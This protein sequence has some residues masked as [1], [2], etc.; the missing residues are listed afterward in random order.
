MSIDYSC[1]KIYKIVS[2]STGLVYIGSTCQKTLAQRLGSHRKSFRL[3]KNPNTVGTGYMTSFILCE[4]DDEEIELIESYPCSN[5][6]ELSSR[7]RQCQRTIDCINQGG[8]SGKNDS[9]TLIRELV[10]QE[11]LPE[12][13]LTRYLEHREIYREYRRKKR[14]A[15]KDKIAKQKREYYVRKREQHAES[16][17]EYREANKEKIADAKKEYYVRNK[18]ILAEKSKEYYARNKEK[19]ADR[20]KEYRKNNKE[21]IAESNK[22]Y[23]SQ[24]VR[25]NVCNKEMRRDTVRRHEKTNS[26][27][28][29]Q[30]LVA[31]ETKIEELDI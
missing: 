9:E 18:E 12:S 28:Y 19:I 3:W 27:K 23:G 1:G 5:R 17:K 22:K 24:R 13:H 26:H 10:E 15:N 30:A 8:K 2:P 6:D 25:C 21:K 11:I 20:D 4:I 29:N 14:E 7:E 31:I 16:T